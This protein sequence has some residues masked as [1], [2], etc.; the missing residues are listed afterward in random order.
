[1]SDCGCGCGNTEAT[2]VQELTLDPPSHRP[3][4]TRTTR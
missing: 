4:T 3:T 2:G 1:M